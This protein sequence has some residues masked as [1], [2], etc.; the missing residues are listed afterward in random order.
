MSRTGRAG[1]KLTRLVLGL[2]LWSEKAHSRMR[3]AAKIAG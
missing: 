3:E 2:T 1:L